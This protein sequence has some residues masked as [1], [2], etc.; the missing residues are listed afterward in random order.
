MK[1]YLVHA[2]NGIVSDMLHPHKRDD[3][4]DIIA[5]SAKIK[6]G[7]YDFDDWTKKVSGDLIFLDILMHKYRGYEQGYTLTVNKDHNYFS[8][9]VV[10]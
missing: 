3:G 10:C 6:K 7:M 5:E 8:Y 1:K 9:I 4:T 2:T